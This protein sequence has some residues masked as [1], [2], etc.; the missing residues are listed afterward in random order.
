ME[1]LPCRK[2]PVALRT[3]GE[4]SHNLCARFSFPIQL[5]CLLQ[6]QKEILALL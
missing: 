5:I 2:L 1:A 6:L 3:E 4:L